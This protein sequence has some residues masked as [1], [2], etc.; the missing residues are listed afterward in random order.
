MKLSM[1][2][3]GIAVA[4]TAA[5]VLAPAAPAR[6]QDVRIGYAIARANIN[7]NKIEQVGRVDPH[8]ASSYSGSFVCQLG[9]VTG[10]VK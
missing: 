2:I 6:A 3:R 7:I 9:I 4:L 5:A 1:P 10:V 8:A